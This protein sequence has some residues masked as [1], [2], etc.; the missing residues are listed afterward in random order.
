MRRLLSL[1]VVAV[2]VLALGGCGSLG[3]YAAKVN[4][5]R[6]DRDEVESELEA[7]LANKEYLDLIDQGAPGQPGAGRVRGAGNDT[8]STT[9]IA[10]LLDRRISLELIHQEVR[11]RDLVPT[12]EQRQAARQQVVGLL[13][14]QELFNGFSKSYRDKLVEQFAEVFA[15]QETLGPPEV[16][17]TEVAEFYEQNRPVFDRTCVRHILVDTEEKAA[18]IKARIVAGEDFAAIAVAESS[19]RGQDGGEGGSAEQGGALGCLP[20]GGLVPEFQQAMD[21]LQP[22]QVSDPVRTQF[23]FHIIEVTSR[24]KLTLE[25]A[26]PE[27]RQRL[28]SQGAGPVAAFVDKAVR[29]AK[30]EVNPRYGTFVKTGQNPG[31]RPPSPPKGAVTT[32]PSAPIPVPQQ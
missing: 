15:L 29:R 14:G 31:V 18:A 6:I 28:Q 26:T 30:I 20:S 25:E 10:A 1:F 4:G 24:Q 11:R 3:G 22:G 8:F 2:A 21:A 19:D 12:A 5:V 13:G 32:P 23:G 9:F 27:I 16:D 7:I 17:P